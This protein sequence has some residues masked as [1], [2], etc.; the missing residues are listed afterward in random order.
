M[1]FHQSLMAFH[2]SL[3]AFYKSLK[4]S[5][6]Y[7]RAD[8]S[9][10]IEVRCVRLFIFISLFANTAA[11]CGQ[12]G[13]LSLPEESFGQADTGSAIQFRDA[14]FLVTTQKHE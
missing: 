4:A 1:A 7:L 10:L 13:P 9:G 2:Q 8:F 12:K 6:V 11:T 5:G 3:M 14:T